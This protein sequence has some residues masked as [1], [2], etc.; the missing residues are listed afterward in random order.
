MVRCARSFGSAP[1]ALDVINKDTFLA[2]LEANLPESVRS[3]RAVY[4]SQLGGLVTDPSLMVTPLDDHMVHR[5]H[6][7]FDTC[8]IANGK[9]YGLDF[10]LDRILRSASLAQI[11][12]SYSKEDLRKLVLHTI[13]AAGKRD[14]VLARFWLSAGRGDFAISPTNCT[15]ASLYVAVT[16]YSFPLGDDP[17]EG[18]AE[19]VVSVPLK[20]TLLATIKSNN[21]ML[22]ALSAMEA[23]SKGGQLGIMVD[24]AG[25]LAEASI[26]CVGLVTQEGVFKTPPFDRILAGTTLIRLL[27]LKQSLLDEQVLT[28]V[29]VGDVHIN[30]LRE[31][32]EICSFGGGSLQAITR[33]DGKMVGDGSLGP[34]TR[35]AHVLLRDDVLHNH[36]FLDDVPWDSYEA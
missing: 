20:P 25:M 28:G 34:F 2:R 18:I 6:A 22:N 30:E 33:L 9:A 5:G 12:H 17:N 23:E 3:V 4:S 21:Y 27:D 11:H 32:R 13:A 8:N 15:G 16:D 35:A 26:A 36:Q 1:Q 29:E 31:A 7:V 24:Q 14:N 19:T 10:H